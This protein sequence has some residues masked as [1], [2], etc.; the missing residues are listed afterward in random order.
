[1]SKIT[2]SFIVLLVFSGNL[3]AQP[4]SK[5]DW[6]ANWITYDKTNNKG[7]SWTIYRKSFYLSK[8]PQL[9]VMANIATDSKYWLYINDQLVV[10]EGGLKRGPTPKDT[11]YD[12][13]EISGHL[14]QGKNTIALLV[15]FWNR[16]GFCHKNSGK[17]GLLFEAHSDH[18]AILS[19]ESWKVAE[20]TAF[21]ETK[22]PFPNYR[23]P[24]YNI[25]FDARQDIF[26]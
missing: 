7:N 20:H 17:S 21:G 13:V 9:S 23:L 1:M 15:W 25:H 10:F 19:D 26:G 6:K 16:D 3:L 2:T 14:Q 11:Y 24:E 4:D 8:A 22:E 5:K 12:E 18:G